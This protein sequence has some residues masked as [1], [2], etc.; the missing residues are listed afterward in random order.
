MQTL[1]HHTLHH[2]AQV[3]FNNYTPEHMEHH[4]GDELHPHHTW[5]LPQLVAQFRTWQILD[6]G[7][8]TVKHNCKDPVNQ[9]AWLIMRLPRSKI[10]PNQTKHPYWAQLT[11]LVL[12]AWR[13]QRPYNTWREYPG[14]EHLVEPLLWDHMQSQPPQLDREELLLLREQACYTRTGKSAGTYRNPK[15]VARPYHLKNTPLAHLSPLTQ[16]VLLDLWIAHPDLR[17]QHQILSPYNWDYHP[18]PLL[19]DEVLPPTPPTPA[20][21]EGQSTTLPWK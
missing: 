11:P 3:L 12:L 21:V 15:S 20:A 16:C 13:D 5:I 7:L 9:V 4:L 2:L 19:V 10:I 6:D 18:E 1:Q 14:L 17:N 8:S